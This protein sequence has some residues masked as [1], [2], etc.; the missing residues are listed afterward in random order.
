M[1]SFHGGFINERETTEDAMRRKAKEE[2]AR[3]ERADLR[4]I[5]VGE[6][7]NRMTEAGQLHL[8]TQKFLLITRVGQRP[9]VYPISIVVLPFD[10]RKKENQVK[11]LYGT[12]HQT[13]DRYN[14]IYNH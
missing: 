1:L 14:T 2:T 11:K 10:Q 4:Q 12:R 6:E 5:S 13:T 8:I 9:L 3:D 7:L